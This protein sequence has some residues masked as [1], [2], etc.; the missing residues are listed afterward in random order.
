MF[1]RR[2]PHWIAYVAAGLMLAHASLSVYWAAGGTLGLSLLSEGI[3]E[4]G[5]ERPA[6]FVALVWGVAL[7]K[8]VV[9]MLALAIARGWSLPIPVWLIKLVVWGTGV[10]LSLYGAVMA[11]TMVVSGIILEITEPE[12]GFW[13]YLFLWAPLWTVIGVSYL[14]TGLRMRAD[15]SSDASSR[16]HS[17]QSHR[18]SST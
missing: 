16:Q 3:Q 9:S 2:I 1:R 5:E 18:S 14:L 10:V 13:A 6:D 4:L 7:V 8:L 15:S 11:V 17:F 12:Q